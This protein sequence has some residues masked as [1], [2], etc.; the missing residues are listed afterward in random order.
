[1]QAGGNMK[2]AISIPVH[3]KIDVIRDQ[4]E[5]IQKFIKCPVIVLHVSASFGELEKL[6]KELSAYQNV[7]INPEH[8][9]T[10]WADIIH[11]HLSNFRFLS[12]QTEFDYFVMHSSN[13]MYVRKDMESYIG[14][15]EAGF[16]I[17]KVTCSNRHWWP[18]YAALRDPA[19]KALMAACGQTMVIASQIEGS[20]YSYDLMKK[21]AD[22]IGCYYEREEG[23]EKYTREEVYFSTVASSL[24]K[25]ENCGKP[26]T[27]SEVHRF[28]RIL[29]KIQD[30]GRRIHRH[31]RWFIPQKAYDKFEVKCNDLLFQ[32]RFYKIRT[33]LVKKIV[34]Q[35]KKCIDKNRYLNDGSGTFQLYDGTEV[36]SVKRVEREYNNRVRQYIRNL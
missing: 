14:R 23:E 16:N 5:N 15:Y 2:I 27:Y 1:M 21:I 22:L 11:T 8:L 24:V 4:I 30:K 31:V 12:A 3:E 9:K 25:W 36:F 18:G 6:E 28:D 33:G 35:D 13:D 10:G 19:L 17:R 29:W 20:F 26:T 32:S 34:I 7:Y